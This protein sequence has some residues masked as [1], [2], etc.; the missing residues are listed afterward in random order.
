MELATDELKKAIPQ[1][2]QFC[3]TCAAKMTR[4][5]PDGDTQMRLAC[6][7]SECGAIVYQNPKVTVASV[8]T[9]A[10][11]KRVLLARRGIPPF[12]GSW[13]IPGGFLETGETLQEGA[14][15][16]CQEE[17]SAS[18]H[19]QGLLGAYDIIAA[20]QVQIVFSG[21]LLNEAGLEA[22]VESQEVK[23]FEWNDI[24]FDEVKLTTHKWALIKA[25]NDVN[26]TAPGDPVEPELRTKPADYDET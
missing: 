11:R 2:N 25:L 5:V 8:V 3:S 10:D 18:I 19:I 22:G 7:S 26:T 23:M 17:T 13:N 14:A 4:V 9:T 24:P 6:S 21:V 20:A 15:R 1:K 12:V 16:E